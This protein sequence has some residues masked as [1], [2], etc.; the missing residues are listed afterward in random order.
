MAARK[1]SKV[2]YFYLWKSLEIIAILFF[3]RF[4]SRPD[5]AIAFIPLLTLTFLTS[6]LDTA[7]HSSGE[8]E[9][10]KFY[11]VLNI[12]SIFLGIVIAGIMILLSSVSSQ[13]YI[14]FMLSSAIA[15]FIGLKTMPE[16]YYLD[17]SPKKVYRAYSR[18]YTIA[19]PLM[20]VLVL[21]KFGFYSAIAGYLA[22]QAIA[23]FLLWK[24]FPIKIKLEKHR[25]ELN[26]ILIQLWKGMLGI[27]LVYVVLILTGFFIGLREF[28]FLFISFVIGS[29]LYRNIT[30]FLA[31][32]LQNKFAEMGY[33]VFK[34]NLIRLIEYTALVAVPCSLVL[35][36]LSEEF[37]Q[38]FLT[39]GNFSEIFIMFLFAGMLKS[40]AEVTRL[41]FFTEEKQDV[42]HRI[43]YIESGLL[44]L[45]SFLL[46]SRIGIQGIALSAAISSVA[47]SLLYLG[48][49]EKLTR[50]DILTV[51][52][53]YFYIFFSGVGTALLL[54]LLKEWFP[55]TGLISLVFFIVLGLGL[56]VAMT[57]MFNREL[58]KR[59]IQFS[60]KL[61]EEKE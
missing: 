29:F 27:D 43:R 39:W 7:R 32:H 44:V 41:V 25:A 50:L 34:F 35:M 15:I 9:E 54:G 33:D 20:A 14:S 30:L 11:N 60:F 17:K 52:R 4:L 24:N 18:A 13:L 12:I 55:I 51:S 22:V 47:S 53:D 58:Y 21:F 5:F 1:L 46:Y 61:V 42:M 19:L 31:G 28:S 56:Y 10:N 26:R 57:L 3:A 8:N 16:V 59:F 48:T 45:L 23:A 40:I 49:A 6:F 38:Y 36:V 37:I 2:G